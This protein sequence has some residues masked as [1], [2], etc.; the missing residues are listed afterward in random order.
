MV[1]KKF[2]KYLENDKCLKLGNI[3]EGYVSILCIVFQLV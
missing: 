2:Y 3:G 1:L